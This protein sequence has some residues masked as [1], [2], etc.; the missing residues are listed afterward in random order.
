MID[1]WE[2]HFSLLLAGF[3]GYSI[4]KQMDML[5]DPGIIS[6]AGGLPSPEMFLKEEVRR[7]SRQRLEDDIETIMQYTGI[8]GEEDFIKAVIAFLKRDGIEA[9]EENIL[10]TNSGQHGLDLTGR[11]FLDSGDV[12]LSDRP[13][14]AGALVAFRM[15]APRF[16]GVSLDEKGSWVEDYKGIIE[17]LL[18]EGRNPKF[19]YVV[20]DF[21]N[22]SG[23]TMSL[24][25][26]KRLLEI[27]SEYSIPIV[28]D[29]PYRDLRYY[30]ET[31]PSIY[32]LDQK[33]GGGRVIGLYTFSKLF[34]PGFRL[35]FNLGPAP[36][37]SKM[38]DIK[39]GNVL[40]TPKYNQDMGTDFLTKVDLDSYLEKCRTYYRAKLEVCLR[41][42][43]ANFP[44]DSGVTWTKPEGGLFI[45]VSLPE[46][47]NTEELLYEAV[48]FKVAFV[49]G[50]AFY[51]DNPETNH[52]R[53]NFS[54][55][56]AEQLTTGIERLAQCIK[57]K[58]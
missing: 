6:L 58:L 12:V 56:S 11:L 20:P 40:N 45:W 30:G 46:R 51:G 26:R 10:I 52:M 32:E 8:R 21:Q 29:S 37:I 44:P 3:E 35:G 38:L 50:S 24:E 31:L 15:Q 54:Y 1:N 34:C 9:A 28:E 48:K 16:A 14:F 18:S 17:A 42:L 5:K 53:L 41:A 22:P 55:P 47:I 49:P 23:V 36:V 33:E 57:N 4:G 7:F 25:R 19:I 27:S 43:E 39:E 13:T 2:S